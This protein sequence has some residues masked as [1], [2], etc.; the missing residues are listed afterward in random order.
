MEDHHEELA[1]WR[2]SGGADIS[3]Q[4]SEESCNALREAARSLANAPHAVADV[5][6]LASQRSGSSRKGGSASVRGI[7]ADPVP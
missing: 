2:G 1:E 3:R 5:D 6:P 7:R 4:H